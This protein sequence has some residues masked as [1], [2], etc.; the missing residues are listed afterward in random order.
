M[1][2]PKCC[3]LTKVLDTRNSMEVSEVYR[4]RICCK[5]E[6]QFYTIEAVAEK[7]R[8]FKQIGRS[9]VKGGRR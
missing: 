3:G 6:H 9:T 4:R 8:Y 7:V 2:C 5:C 1:R